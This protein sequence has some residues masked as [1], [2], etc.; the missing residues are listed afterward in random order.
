MIM[1]PGVLVCGRV[2]TPYEGLPAPA[3]RCW[4]F[5]VSCPKGSPGVGLITGNL[6]RLER[7]VACP[8]SAQRALH[9]GEAL[10]EHVGIDLCSSHVGMAKQ[11]LHRTNIAATA[12]QLG[13]KGMAERMAAG[14]LAYRRFAHRKPNRL[15]YSGD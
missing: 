2:L 3:C 12:Q 14:W 4:H 11:R 8:Y 13:R 7:A 9:T 1:R 6:H 10:A 15:L 5:A